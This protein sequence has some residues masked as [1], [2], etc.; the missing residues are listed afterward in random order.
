MNFIGPMTPTLIVGISGRGGGQAARTGMNITSIATTANITFTCLD[1]FF[2][3][4]FFLII[5]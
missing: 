4:S 5:S 2:T 1:I 3:S